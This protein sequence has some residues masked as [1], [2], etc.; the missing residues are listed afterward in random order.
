MKQ[1]K[2]WDGDKYVHFEGVLICSQAGHTRDVEVPKLWKLSDG[3]Y[4][5]GL[6]HQDRGDLMTDVKFYTRKPPK[7]ILNKFH[8]TSYFYQA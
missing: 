7:S 1:E 8:D 4:M 5:Y 3:R 2:Y 6:T